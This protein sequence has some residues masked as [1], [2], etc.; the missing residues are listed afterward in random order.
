M[1]SKK[2]TQGLKIFSKYYSCPNNI[3]FFQNCKPIWYSHLSQVPRLDIISTD[4]YLVK[5][6]RCFLVSTCAVGKE[7][8]DCGL[9]NSP[10]Q[11]PLG[12]YVLQ[13][14]WNIERYI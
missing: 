1:I 8:K 5:V 11:I 9:L 6:L 4:I 7:Q 12:Y 2:F 3:H 13:V 10:Q 14:K